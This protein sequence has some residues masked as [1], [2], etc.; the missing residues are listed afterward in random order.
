M[1]KYNH[2]APWARQDILDE[3]AK[4]ERPAPQ[5]VD[6]EAPLDVPRFS[7][8]QQGEVIDRWY[9]RPGIVGPLLIA[10]GLVGLVAALMWGAW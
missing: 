8:L 6:R 3:I 1:T 9:D 10:A 2:G 7:G 4:A 5:L